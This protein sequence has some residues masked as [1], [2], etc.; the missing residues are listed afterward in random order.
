MHTKQIMI[1][2]CLTKVK[3]ACVMWC[4]EVCEKFA[5]CHTFTLQCQDEGVSILQN[6]GTV[7]TMLE[8]NTCHRTACSVWTWGCP[9]AGHTGIWGCGSTILLIHNLGTR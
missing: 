5:Y 8:G 6:I 4:C 9:W 7:S 2:K 1:Y 3:I